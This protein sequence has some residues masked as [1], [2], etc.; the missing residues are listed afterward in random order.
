MVSLHLV[1][2]GVLYYTTH[3]QS[4]VDD[5]PTQKQTP[6]VHQRHH[7]NLFEWISS[8]RSS[9]SLLLWKYGRERV[10][11]KN[12]T[13][14]NKAPSNQV[15][16]CHWAATATARMATAIDA[17]ASATPISILLSI[18]ISIYIDL[19]ADLCPRLSCNANLH[20]NLSAL[21]LTVK[22]T[23]AIFLL[24]LKFF[25]FSRFCVCVSLRPSSLYSIV[26]YEIADDCVV[27]LFNRL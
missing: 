1:R 3:H 23:L 20:P 7:Q 11:N 5:E 12:T 8:E 25:S 14:H 4:I 18:K 10:E 6:P 19:E 13:T 9:F 24:Y 2:Q 21:P 22:L 17:A 27:L 26:L 15:H 16:L